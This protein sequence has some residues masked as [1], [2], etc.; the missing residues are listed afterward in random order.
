MFVYFDIEAQQDTGDHVANLV[1][2]E[3]DQNDG[4]FIFKGEHCIYE[5][6]QWVHT[7]A[8]QPNVEKVIVVA[9]KFKGYDGY[10]ILEEL[11]KQ[12]VTNLSQIVNGGK[13]LSL[14]IPNV[15]F[16]DS[17]NFF[18][19]ALSNFPETFRINELKKGFFPHF[20]NIQENQK[21]AGCMPDKS[22]YDPDG[23]SPA[24]K[25]EFLRW[26]DDKVFQ[27]Y[28]FNFQDELL[29][30]CQSDVRLLKQGC[31]T[32]QSQF[33]DIVNFNPMKECITIASACNVAYRKQW[34]PSHKIAVEPV[35][36][37]RPKHN[38]SHVA[39]KWLYW[40]ENKPVKSDLLPRITH[41]G[42]RSER[43]LMHGTKS[44]LVDGYDEQTRTVHK[45][46]G[47]FYYGCL[48]CFPNRSMKHPIHLNKTMYD[49]REE[50]RDKIEQLATLGYHVREMW[51]C[52]WNLMTNTNLQ[53]K[54]FVD[55]LDIVPPLN[56]HEAFFGG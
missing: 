43:A 48:R 33:K 8:N 44:L 53:V 10:F 54:E 32:L 49:V 19:M 55:K 15:K 2:A 51:E 14:E 39:L 56:P 40:E 38:Q 50:T 35:R 22:Y 27:R 31:M 11:Y 9:H 4:Q 5:F 26:Y 6:L 52:E 46:Q 25:E 12:Q 28:V 24:R 3:T 18:R 21:Y 34:M 45:F 36:G 1:C 13:I 41:V 16:I 29:T 42:N 30:Y 23:T 7:I 20:F 47:C 17:M 37:W